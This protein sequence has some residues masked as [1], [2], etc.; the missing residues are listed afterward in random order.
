MPD[1]DGQSNSTGNL[2]EVESGGAGVEE[3]SGKESLWRGLFWVVVVVVVILVVILIINL[4]SDSPPPS[5]SPSPA[6]APPSPPPA[7]P[8]PPVPAP[9]EPPAPPAPPVPPAVPAPAVPA[10]ALPAPAVPAPAVPASS[11]SP[12]PAASEAATSVES[13]L[14]D[15]LPINCSGYWS[16]WTQCTE[17]CGGGTQENTYIITQQPTGE[18]ASPCPST[19]TRACNEDACPQDCEGSWSICGADCADKTY[20]V[21]VPQSG[22]GSP[23]E[24]ANGATAPCSPGEGG[25]PVQDLPPNPEPVSYS[26]QDNYW[27]VARN[28][29]QSPISYSQWFMTNQHNGFYLQIDNDPDPST[30]CGLPSRLCPA[31][32]K[33]QLLCNTQSGND[34]NIREVVDQ[35]GDSIREYDHSWDQLETPDW[36]SAECT[37]Y[38]ITGRNQRGSDDSECNNS[39]VSC[40]CKF[41]YEDDKKPTDNHLGV[42]NSSINYMNQSSRNQSGKKYKYMKKDI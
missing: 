13:S 41:V 42:S 4:I 26:L 37:G 20:T 19:Q 11:P 17:S 27:Y 36:S 1:T 32:E 2:G 31:E 9:P 34:N 40:G 14:N 35:L 29:L 8:A 21:S 39:H 3:K 16:G 15:P 18:G 25:C 10:P 6:P 38:L 5:S 22:T 23:C 30:P 33:C 7:P 28:S 12:S 24:A